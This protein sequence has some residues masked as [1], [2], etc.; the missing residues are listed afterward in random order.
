[1]VARIASSAFLQAPILFPDFTH[2]SARMSGDFCLLG[3]NEAG[4]KVKDMGSGSYGLRRGLLVQ[5]WY[6]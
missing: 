3:F 2:T 6:W 1:M 5:E 4:C